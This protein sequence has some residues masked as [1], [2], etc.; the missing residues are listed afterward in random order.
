MI[1][2]NVEIKNKS[3][4]NKIKNPKKYLKEKLKIVSKTIPFFLKKKIN[5]TILLTNS[6]TMKKL[7]RKFRKKNKTTDVLSFPFFSRKKLKSLKEKNI[8][9]GDIALN[10]EIINKRA[11]KKNFLFEFDKTWVHGLLHLLGY[12]HIKIKDYIRM[13]R[14]EKKILNL[15]N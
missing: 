12:N 2:V 1:K 3:W 15:L 9:L 6:I 10:Y 14:L 8:Y 11:E 5:F 4:Q 13:N 7:N